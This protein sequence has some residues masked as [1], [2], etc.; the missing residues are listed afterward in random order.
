M[1]LFQ[2]FAFLLKQQYLGIAISFKVYTL[3]QTEQLK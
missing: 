3:W 2:I 1:L